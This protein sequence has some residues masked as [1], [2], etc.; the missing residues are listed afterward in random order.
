MTADRT[1]NIDDYPVANLALKA[2]SCILVLHS[3]HY[4]R[5]EITN[6]ESVVG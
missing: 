1:T 6:N 4:T 3:L 5:N 2:S